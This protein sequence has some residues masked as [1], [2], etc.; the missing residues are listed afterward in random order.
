MLH[1]VSNKREFGIVWGRMCATS[2]KSND[3]WWLHG[4]EFLELSQKQNQKQGVER[5]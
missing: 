2:G 5:I 3:S 1:D 4:F